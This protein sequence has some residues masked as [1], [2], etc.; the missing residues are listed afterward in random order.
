MR[1][2][3]RR[4]LEKNMDKLDSLISEITDL[5][6]SRGISKQIYTNV[7]QD[8]ISR[9]LTEI[10]RIV[11]SFD[12]QKKNEKRNIEEDLS[13]VDSQTGKRV[14]LVDIDRMNN[15]VEHV[16]E[17][18]DIYA[19]LKSLAISNKCAHALIHSTDQIKE[20]IEYWKNEKNAS[21]AKDEKS[22][23]EFDI[24]SISECEM[25][26][27]IKQFKKTPK[28]RGAI[29]NVCK[30][31]GIDISDIK[32]DEIALRELYEKIKN[33]REDI[34]DRYISG[35]NEDLNKKEDARK[36][37]FWI[38]DQLIV[39]IAQLLKN[40]ERYKNFEY[41]MV[42]NGEPP[43]QNML[44]IDDPDLSY[45]IEVHMPDY[46]ANTLVKEYGISEP[47]EN[48]KRKFEK[49]GAS[50]IY[51]RDDKEIRNILLRSLDNIRARII[52]RN[53]SVNASD[54]RND[55][56][57]GEGVRNKEKNEEDK[58]NT[59][60][61]KYTFV[62]NRIL[63]NPNVGI[64]ENFLLK[65]PIVIAIRD[66][67]RYKY[68]LLRSDEG[69]D[70]IEIRITEDTISTINALMAGKAKGENNRVYVALRKYAVDALQNGD[71]YDEILL[72]YAKGLSSPS[73]FLKCI[74]YA[75]IYKDDYYRKE[76]TLNRLLVL[77]HMR[78]DKE[79][80]DSLVEIYRKEKMEKMEEIKGNPFEG[81]K[82]FL[83]RLN[84][85]RKKYFSE[86]SNE[87][88]KRKFDK[89]TNKEEVEYPDENIL[90]LKKELKEYIE[91]MHRKAKNGKDGDDIDGR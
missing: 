43:F 88:F 65:E 49:L 83:N 30:T 22:E 80:L 56:S 70:N 62:T 28:N 84:R 72:N 47:V 61:S 78:E 23:I 86:Y 13:I 39:I 19:I 85:N 32:G 53:K 67:K 5:F 26:K 31:L 16:L 6:I 79:K 36:S 51:R 3:E 45:Y 75:K 38:K 17:E 63:E 73:E 11:G 90:R 15:A 10:S 12:K 14:N 71:E 91:M 44:A 20:R 81:K 29:I 41:E 89:Y 76:K 9:N 57:G 66:M 60:P 35:L 25:K 50:A 1:S 2:V 34:I 59:R 64:L 18:N 74:A 4:Y 68:A 87:F 27:L 69:L 52:S 40:D 77:E 21:C 55:G 24:S 58:R 37:M 54:D 42:K 46:I 33:S 7:E 48:D 82:L 8:I